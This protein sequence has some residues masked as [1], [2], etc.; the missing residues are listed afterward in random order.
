MNQEQFETLSRVAPV[1][2][3][4][5]AEEIPAP[6]FDR[7]LLYGYDV[8]RRTWHVYLKDGLIHR[9]VRA[10]HSISDGW[11]HQSGKV[12]RLADLVPSKRAYPERTDFY[13]ARLAEQRDV[14]IAFTGF[15]A[16]VKPA[17]FYGPVV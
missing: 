10:G 15:N 4:V 12:W 8:D 17:Q 5:S 9:V 13:F 11:E 16:D 1:A 3:T 14:P 2:A 7:T 6:D